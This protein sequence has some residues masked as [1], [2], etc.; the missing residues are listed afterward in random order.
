MFKRVFL[1]VLDGV[2]CGACLMLEFMEITRP[3]RWPMWRPVMAHCRYRT[4]QRLGL[5][6]IVSMKGVP[7]AD[8]PEAAWGRM[9]E[10]SAGK[11]STTGHWEIAGA[12]LQQPFRTFPEAFPPAIIQAFTELAGVEPL[13]NVIASGTEILVELGEEHLRTG[14]PII[15]TSSDSVFQIAAHESLWPPEK[16]YALCRGM[17]DVLNDWQVGG[18]VIARPFVGDRRRRLNAR[19][20]DMIFPCSRHPCSLMRWPSGRSR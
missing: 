12:I 18:R 4:L 1:I 19:S 13:G 2:G 6:N 3:I 9:A 14:R 15:Y 20:D 11:D 5:G 7:P 16:L 17:R 8:S 10:Q